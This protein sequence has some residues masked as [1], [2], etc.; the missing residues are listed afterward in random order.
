MMTQSFLRRPG[1]FASPF[2]FFF[3]FAV[4]FSNI[5]CII[6]D[7]LIVRRAFA[8]ITGYSY[9]LLF[10]LFVV[11]GQVIMYRILYYDS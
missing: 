5:L 7:V 2:F 9:T 6:P 10:T 4:F 8:Y 3:W 1:R 11:Y